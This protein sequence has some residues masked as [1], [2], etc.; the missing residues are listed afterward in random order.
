[1]KEAVKAGPD[2][3]HDGDLRGVVFHRPGEGPGSYQI[4]KRNVADK[5][6]VERAHHGDARGGFVPIHGG[7]P[8]EGGIHQVNDSDNA[9]DDLGHF[10]LLLQRVEPPCAYD[11]AGQAP[12]TEQRKFFELGCVPGIRK[13]PHPAPLSSQ[14]A[15]GKPTRLA[16]TEICP[17]LFASLLHVWR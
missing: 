7:E 16:I 9:E 14:F 8:H 15:A 4:D 17:F 12:V 1:M 11:E 6:Q 10:K 13:E 5:M 3:A 2:G